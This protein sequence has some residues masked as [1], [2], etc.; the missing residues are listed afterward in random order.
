MGEVKGNDAKHKLGIFPCHGQGGNQVGAHPAPVKSFKS[1][2]M[3]CKN[4]NNFYDFTFQM[5]KNDEY[6]LNNNAFFVVVFLDPVRRAFG[7][8][9]KVGYLFN[10][11][12]NL[13]RI[14]LFCTWVY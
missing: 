13:N 10:W 4:D 14:Y 5:T 9:S 8:F 11:V 12:L 2:D 3:N 1:P 6:N 7:L